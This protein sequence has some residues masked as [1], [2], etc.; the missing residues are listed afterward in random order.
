M[1]TQP[2]V[3]SVR[4]FDFEEMVRDYGLSIFK[5][6]Y[7]IVG[8]REL[9]ED[10][11]QEV[12]LAAYLGLSSLQDKAK[13]KSWLWKIAMNKC[14]DYWRKESTARAFWENKVHLYWKHE[15]QESPVP[16]E[17]LLRKNTKDELVKAIRELP[18]RYR[19]PLLLFYFRGQSLAEIS[20]YTRLPIATVKT[21]MK[22]AKEQ[23]RSK[24]IT[25]I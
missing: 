9:A 5:Y 19:E 16:E 2:A 7:S 20:D 24:V 22:R 4:E 17:K 18:E 21:R 12:L 15:F 23:L 3:N 1:L 25:L 10:L 8:H 11:Y 6:L 13:V 14:R